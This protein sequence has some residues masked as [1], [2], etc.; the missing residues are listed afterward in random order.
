MGQK[1]HPSGFRLGITE[2]HRSCW[3]SKTSNYPI[4]LQEDYQI[5]NYISKKYAHTGILNIQIYR[6]VDQVEIVL[7]TARP[8][9]IVGKSGA[10]IDLLRQGLHDLLG[11]NKRIRINIIEVAVPDAE[12]ALVAEFI[13][14]QLELRVPFR[15]VVRQVIQ[16]ARRVNIKG[17][18]VQVSGRLN[19]AEIARSEWVREGRVPLQT[20]RANVDYSYKRAYTTYGV[21]GVKVWLFKGELLKKISYLDS[22][23]N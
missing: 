6:K 23:N 11:P 13:T 15:R 16:K 12:A 2:E 3:F 10:G 21:L 18:K 22:Q 20:L 4:L 9:I 17:I 19:G 14:Q 8:G 1:I 7:E 5:R